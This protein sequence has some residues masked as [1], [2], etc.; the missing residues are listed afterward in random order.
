MWLSC[1]ERL[2]GAKDGAGTRKL[3]EV[4]PPV[5]KQS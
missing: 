1:N 5:L 4:N 2:T 3:L